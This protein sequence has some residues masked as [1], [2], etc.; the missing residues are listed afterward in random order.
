MRMF[1]GGNV[2]FIRASFEPRTPDSADIL[3]LSPA[4]T[5]PISQNII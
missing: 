3:S 2:F 4:S 1:K 5:K